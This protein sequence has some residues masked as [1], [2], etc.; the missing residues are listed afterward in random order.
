MTGSEKDRSKRK[1]NPFSCGSQF[2]SGGFR[3]NFKIVR[4]EKNEKTPVHPGETD[5][6]KESEFTSDKE[7]N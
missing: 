2:L 1:L 5:R 4:A 6:V 7:L 3:P